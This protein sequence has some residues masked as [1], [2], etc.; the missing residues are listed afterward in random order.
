[1]YVS[2]HTACINQLFCCAHPE[3]YQKESSLLIN[4]LRGML[5][6]L[7]DSGEPNVAQKS[8]R[9]SGRKGFNSFQRSEILAWCFCEICLEEKKFPSHFNKC[10]CLNCELSLQLSSNLLPYVFPFLSVLNIKITCLHSSNN[11]SA[12]PYFCYFKS[13]SAAIHCSSIFSIKLAINIYYLFCLITLISGTIFIF[14]CPS[15]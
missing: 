12:V 14:K 5:K 8:P 9:G 15:T 7:C 2:S 6:R 1:M 13:L 4:E 11:P 3:N 10:K